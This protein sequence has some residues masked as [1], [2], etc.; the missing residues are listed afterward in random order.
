VISV[1]T[2]CPRPGSSPFG[3]FLNIFLFSEK[4]RHRRDV[5]RLRNRGLFQSLAEPESHCLQRARKPAFSRAAKFRFPVV[6]GVGQPGQ[7]EYKDYGVP[8]EFPSDGCRGYDSP[9]R[10]AGG[11]HARLPEW[12]RAL[13]VPHSRRWRRGARKPMS[14]CV[15]AS[16]SRRGPAQQPV[17]RRCQAV[18]GLSR[19]P[20]I[21]HLF[22][23]KSER[24]EQTELLVLITPQLVRPLNPTRSRRCRRCSSAPEA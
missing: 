3:D 5:P 22:R 8:A 24:A 21:G 10:A 6:S 20:I 19:L 2:S 9:A 14:S 4:Y 23:S 18:P 1:R 13:R 7:R 17:R 16:R 15:M 12:H 11:Q